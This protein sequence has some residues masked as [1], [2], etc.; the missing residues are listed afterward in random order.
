MAQR[1]NTIRSW[2]LSQKLVTLK[3]SLLLFSL[4]ILSDE[5]SVIRLFDII[6]FILE[7]NSERKHVMVSLGAISDLKLKK[8]TLD[9]TVSSG[10]VKLQDLFYAM[11]SVSSSR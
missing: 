6:F 4:L 7:D 11:R 9:W 1:T 8:R 3:H 10:A 2:S 5:F